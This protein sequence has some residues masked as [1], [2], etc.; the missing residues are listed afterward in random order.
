MLYILGA[1]FRPADIVLTNERLA[2][3]A[4]SFTASEIESQYGI[5][6]RRSTLPADYFEKTK[7]ADA[8]EAFKAALA[9]P[10]DLAMDSVVDAL[11]KAG[12]TKE[13]IGL[14][15][16][17]TATPTQ[18]TPSEGQRVAGRLGLKVPTYD[19]WMASGS[20]I[21][22]LEALSAFQ[23]AK[24]PEYV[25]GLSANAPTQSLDLSS[26][27]TC[28]LYGD[29]AASYVLSGSH[30]GKLKVLRTFLD[31]K[32]AECSEAKISLYGALS[33]PDSYVEK[34]IRPRTRE[35]LE[36]IRSWFPDDLRDGYFIGSQCD[37]S[38]SRSVAKEFGFDAARV[39]TNGDRYGDML[40]TSIPSV[41][42]ENWEKLER[43][44]KIFIAQSG[45]ALCRGGMVLEV[46]N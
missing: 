4:N 10:T 36:Q 18:I 5:L 38:G 22:Q 25:L 12:I 39:L 11:S 31:V 20:F 33:V 2:A 23:P 13:Q 3:L 7:G 9:T 29:G 14:V 16:G 15:V 43:G 34:N 44:R 17:D 30:E 19:L 26:G 8:M 37:V 1:G 35:A 32:P 24:L 28:A 41:L 27:A 45:I 46:V 21:A 6:S 42:A 40:G